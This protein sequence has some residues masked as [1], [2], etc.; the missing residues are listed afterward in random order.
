MSVYSFFSC[1]SL[2][3]FYD[4]KELLLL[5]LGNN[6]RLYW[7]S[8]FHSYLSLSYFLW[9]KLYQLV[10]LQ[11][12]LRLP[13]VTPRWTL[14]LCLFYDLLLFFNLLT[15]LLHHLLLIYLIKYLFFKVIFLLF[16]F[17]FI[18]KHLFYLLYLWHLLLY[19]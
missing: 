17:F 11:I 7:F 16:I 19:L 14:L 3:N 18:F 2:L 12:I 1:S 8:F 9:H 10:C 6:N 13:T 4:Y 15:Q 5:F